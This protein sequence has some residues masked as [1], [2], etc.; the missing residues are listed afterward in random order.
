MTKNFF[1]IGLEKFQLMLG[2]NEFFRK[3]SPS[4][5]PLPMPELH[6]LLRRDPKFAS[7]SPYNVPLPSPNAIRNQRG[8][9]RE[10]ERERERHTAEALSSTDAID[11]FD[12]LKRLIGQNTH[13][14]VD[15]SENRSYRKS[16]IDLL[17][18]HVFHSKMLPVLVKP[19]I[20]LCVNIQ[21]KEGPF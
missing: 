8:E 2:E 20:Y 15:H 10:R 5:Q 9:G 17:W 4:P 11:G 1:A 19:F 13:P 18:L 14:K 6:V 21:F 7:S 12:G 16:R 3:R